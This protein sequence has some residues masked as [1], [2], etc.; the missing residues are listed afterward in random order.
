MIAV[1][2]RNTCRYCLRQR[3]FLGGATVCNHFGHR[4]IDWSTAFIIVS[5]RCLLA[6]IKCK[7]T[8]FGAIAV[9][10]FINLVKS[11]SIFYESINN[12]L[13]CVNYLF[14]VPKVLPDLSRQQLIDYDLAVCLQD[15]MKISY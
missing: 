7:D 5:L 13:A 4:L 12:L 2:I 11:E 9:Y 8:H 14:A 3:K 10:G 15:A 1:Y 6:F